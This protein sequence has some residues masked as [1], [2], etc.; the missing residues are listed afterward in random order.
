M[1]CTLQEELEIGLSSVTSLFFIFF[2]IL[3]FFIFRLHDRIRHCVS[4]GE[5]TESLGYAP[6]LRLQRSA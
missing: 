4:A 5:A 1:V 6:S 2:S 3:W